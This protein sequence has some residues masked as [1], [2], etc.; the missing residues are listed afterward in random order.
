MEEEIEGV[1]CCSEGRSNCS[2]SR[3][4]NPNN[5]PISAAYRQC[6]RTDPLVIP[7]R[8]SLVRH[9]SLVRKV[10]F[11]LFCFYSVYFHCDNDVTS[12]LLFVDR[13]RKVSSFVV[14][15]SYIIY[16]FS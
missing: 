10:L 4:P 11:F 6:Q 14:L 2:E 3:P 7:C 8:K 1:N 5:P 12:F 15:N 13:N 9:A 16:Y